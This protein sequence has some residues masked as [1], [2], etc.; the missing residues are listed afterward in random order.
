MRSPFYF[1]VEPLEGK[2]YNN[3]KEISGV[4]FIISSSEEDHKASNRQGVVVE[5]PLNY[6]GPI[7]K[8]DIL[9]VHHNVFKFYNDMK[10]RQQSGKSYFKDNLFFIDNEQFY[11]YKQDNKWHS[12]DRYCFVKPLKKQDSY[13]LKRGQEEPLMGQ[14]VYPN[15]YLISKGVLS[16]DN[17]CFKPD[18]EYEFEVDGEKL[19]RMFDHQ[20]TLML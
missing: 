15:D 16:G 4:D 19:Y 5:V 3:S 9:L 17:V 1:I 8:D 11:M 7:K 14:M 13:I 20:I 12:H 18:S 6:T 2:R 10:G